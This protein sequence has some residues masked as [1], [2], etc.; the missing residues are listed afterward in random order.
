MK[1]KILCAVL[2][3]TLVA[4]LAACGG[5]S[6]AGTGT[7]EAKEETK[8]EAG[9]LTPIKV[10]ASTTPHAEILAQAKEALAEKGYDLQVTE[11]ADYVQPNNVVESGEFDANYFQHINYLNS[12][13]EEHGT[14]LVNAGSIH[15]EPFG[16]YPGTES[17][18]ANISEGATIAVPNDTTNEARA[19]LLLEESGLITL[20]EGVGIN[21]TKLDIVDNPKNLEILELEA[22]QISRMLDEVAFGVLNGNYALQAGLNVKDDA[23]ACENSESEAIVEQY[24]NIIAVK[25]G[26]ENAP[27]VQALVEVLRSDVIVN[28]INDTYNGAVVPFTE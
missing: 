13:N 27:A 22:A 1:K 4:G 19:L 2:S 9:S 15:Y 7:A 11:F 21:A 23:V 26:S 20:K 12:F 14:H 24:V 25:E 5:S 6:D 10:A 17:D 3:L 28:Y 16:I 8:T 18:L